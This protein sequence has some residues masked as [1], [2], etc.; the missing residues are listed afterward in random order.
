VIC[1]EKEKERQRHSEFLKG[2]GKPQQDGALVV[3][4]A[5]L[6]VVLRSF[7]S[8]DADILA[9]YLCEVL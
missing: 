5:W 1:V 2:Q 9:V 8:V 7:C 3:S 6:V 4:G